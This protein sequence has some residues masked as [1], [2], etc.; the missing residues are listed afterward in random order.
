MQLILHL[1]GKLGDKSDDQT[2]L[3]SGK[4]E[5]FQIRFVTD[6]FEFDMEAA[7]AGAMQNDK[8]FSITYNLGNC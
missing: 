1:N 2:I 3:I 6:G 7:G 4:K 8:G 5:P